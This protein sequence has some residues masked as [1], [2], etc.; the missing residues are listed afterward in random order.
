MMDMHPYISCCLKQI[1]LLEMRF[2]S[3][4]HHTNS[5]SVEHPA[6]ENKIFHKVFLKHTLP[7]I[8]HIHT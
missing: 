5:K 8:N 7:F 6:A 2:L 3:V 1:L 4:M